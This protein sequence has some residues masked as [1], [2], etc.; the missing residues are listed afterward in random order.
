M[1]NKNMD[2]S[3]SAAATSG[4]KLEPVLNFEDMM[5]EEE[6]NEKLKIEHHRRIS[7][8]DNDGKF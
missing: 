4:D 5:R 8:L 2:L 6:N 3:A 1:A 7:K